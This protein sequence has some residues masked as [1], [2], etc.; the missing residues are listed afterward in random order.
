M[1]PEVAGKWPDSRKQFTGSNWNSGPSATRRRQVNLARSNEH[2]ANIPAPG[3][4]GQEDSNGSCSIVGRRGSSNGKGASSADVPATREPSAQHGQRG[5]TPDGFYPYASNCSCE[6]QTQGNSS[7]AATATP[8][9]QQQGDDRVNLARSNEH[10]ANI[11]APGRT[12]QEDSNGSCSSVGR[13]G[14]SNGKG[15][16]SADVPATREPSAQHG[17]R[18]VTTAES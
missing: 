3:R 15:A 13:R 16:S 2:R 7:P 6:G 9:R 12:G 5:V 1:V 10:R 4:T 8:G 17:Q 11:P 14:S 18:G